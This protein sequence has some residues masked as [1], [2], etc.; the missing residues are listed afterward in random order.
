MNRSCIVASFV[1][2]LRLPP[3]LTSLYMNLRRVE[4]LRRDK[5][6]GQERLMM[7]SC[8]RYTAAVSASGY[9][10]LQG[11]TAASTA[12]SEIEHGACTVRSA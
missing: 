1:P 9:R 8:G 3:T 4:K 11:D 10:F 2:H 5:T 7:Q 12:A 6:S